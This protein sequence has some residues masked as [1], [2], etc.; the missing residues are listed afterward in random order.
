MGFVDGACSDGAC[1]VDGVSGRGT[2]AS[3]A[4]TVF[5]TVESPWPDCWT[6]FFSA[7]DVDCR[8]VAFRFFCFADLA[9]HGR[10]GLEYHGSYQSQNVSCES[11]MNYLLVASMGSESQ[12]HPLLVF[13]QGTEELLGRAESEVYR[14]AE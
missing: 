10:S 14:V 4:S 9:G 11:D 5:E 7:N 3:V 1:V 6:S 13:L 2:E 8:G 12:M